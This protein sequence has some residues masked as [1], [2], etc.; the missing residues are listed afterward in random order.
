MRVS[1]W[2]IGIFTLIL[3]AVL[4]SSCRTAPPDSFPVES[5]SNI[6]NWLPEDSDL[7]VKLNV[8]GNE[9]LAKITVSLL[10]LNAEDFSPVINRTVILAAGFNMER[11]NMHSDQI[12]FNAIAVGLWPRYFLG[13]ALGK[14]W[15]RNRSAKYLWDGPSNLSLIA[16]SNREIFVSRGALETLIFLRGNSQSGHV[17][18]RFPE[19]ADLALLLTNSD[20]IT[21]SLPIALGQ[22]EV[23]NAAVH[24][25]ES[26]YY[27]QFGIFPKQEALIG[28]LALALRLGLSARF[29]LSADPV[30]KQLLQ[31]LE[32]NKLP[33]Q[34]QL[35]FPPIP[36]YLLERLARELKVFPQGSL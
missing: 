25:H 36:L 5:Y 30:E 3:L 31:D 23:M 13:P 28:P 27:L 2:R 11:R 29:G 20:F 32:V 12:L 21:Q 1:F 14:D 18:S 34:V 26:G 8:P 19:D 35:V 33:G 4:L 7:L 10:G 6:M 22:V 9:D 24:R 15:K 17:L 16:P